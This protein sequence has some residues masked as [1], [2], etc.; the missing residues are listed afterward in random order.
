MFRSIGAGG[1]ELIQVLM[2]NTNPVI[3]TRIFDELTFRLV[4][5]ASMDVEVVQNQLAVERDS[6]VDGVADKLV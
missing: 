2:S 3:F 6:T 5:K 1:R 4:T